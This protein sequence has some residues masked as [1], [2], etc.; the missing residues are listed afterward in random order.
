MYDP[1]QIDEGWLLA[2]YISVNQ[3]ISSSN[4]GTQVSGHV[5]VSGWIS[6]VP[7][8]EVPTSID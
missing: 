6:L 4:L 2:G 8:S 3:H 1:C 7:K 5:A